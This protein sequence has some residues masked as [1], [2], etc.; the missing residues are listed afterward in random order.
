MAKADV[1]HSISKK[2]QLYKDQKVD[3]LDINQLKENYELT[4]SFKSP[5]SLYKERYQGVFPHCRLW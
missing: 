5:K 3:V 2:F 4:A 1:A